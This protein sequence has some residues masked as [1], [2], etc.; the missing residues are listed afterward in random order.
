VVARRWAHTAVA[1]A[2]AHRGAALIC[3]AARGSRPVE[4][5][6]AWGPQSVGAPYRAACS[7]RIAVVSN[8]QPLVCKSEPDGHRV[9][10]GPMASWNAQFSGWFVSTVSAE[11]RAV[12]ARLG[13][14][15]AQRGFRG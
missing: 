8:R 14:L 6:L 12:F 13:T 4:M 5:R 15:L 11:C 2:G 9:S 3:E 10:L 7:P 1:A